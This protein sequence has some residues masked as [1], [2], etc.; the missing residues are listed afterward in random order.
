MKLLASIKAITLYAY[1]LVFLLSLML[2]IN[3]KNEF[4]FMLAMFL[5]SVRC[6]TI[7]CFVFHRFLSFFKIKKEYYTTEI[8]L[9]V[10]CILLTLIFSGK[11]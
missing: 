4:T 10:Y 11:I 2:I 3:A 7:W 1:F 6:N 9:K 5:V 8:L